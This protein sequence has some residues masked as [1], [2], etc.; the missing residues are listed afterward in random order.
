MRNTYGSSLYGIVPSDNFYELMYPEIA[1]CGNFPDD[2]SYDFLLDLN[3]KLTSLHINNILSI[4]D[5]DENFPNT[6]FTLG[7]SLIIEHLKAANQDSNILVY[8][9]IDE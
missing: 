7:D 5:R 4:I 3:Y 8:I 2:D 1:P 6:G 9:Y